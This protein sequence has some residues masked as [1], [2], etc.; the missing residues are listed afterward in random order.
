M[1]RT[2]YSEECGE[3]HMKLFCNQMQK[4]WLWKFVYDFIRVWW[5]WYTV[6]PALRDRS[7]DWKSGLLRQVVSSQVNYSKKMCFWGSERAVS[8][9]RWSL[10]TGD[11]KDR[12][13]YIIPICVIHKLLQF[14]Y[15][16]CNLPTLLFNYNLMGLYKDCICSKLTHSKFSLSLSLSLSFSW[17]SNTCEFTHLVSLYMN[18]VCPLVHGFRAL[19]IHNDY[20]SLTTPIPLV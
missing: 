20:N 13:D 7:R 5:P 17:A 1:K 12:F 9:C 10:N 16:Q 18:W 15:M 14:D 4:N 8:S 19:G 3:T 11:L 2:L 6:K